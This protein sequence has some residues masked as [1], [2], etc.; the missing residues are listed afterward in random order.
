LGESEPESVLNV[1]PAAHKDS[2][3]AILVMMRRGADIPFSAD[4][5]SLQVL[6]VPSILQLV[7]LFVII[8]GILHR[9]HPDPSKNF[10]RNLLTCLWASASIVDQPSIRPR[11]ERKSFHRLKWLTKSFKELKFGGSGSI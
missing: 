9:D 10:G 1:C 2:V 11:R 6:V 8:L 4:K 5:L 3:R 7:Q